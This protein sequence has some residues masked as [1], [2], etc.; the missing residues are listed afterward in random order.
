MKSVPYLHHAHLAVLFTLFSCGQASTDE[1]PVAETNQED[2]QTKVVNVKTE[3]L[4]PQDFA[5]TY[6]VIGHVE[7]KDDVV[8]SSE[9]SG[10]ILRYWV[11]EGYRVKAGQALAKIDDALLLAERDRLIA[12]VNQSKENY[13]R[14]GRLWNE[15][16]IGS[17][18]DFINAKYTFQQ[19]EA[20][21]KNV[22]TQIE[23]T[24]LKAPFA[25]VVDRKLTNM[26]ETVA[27]GTQML[28]LIDDRTIIVAGGVPS[29]YANV[30]KKGSPVKISLESH[31]DT[32]FTGYIQFVAPS[33]DPRSRTFRIEVELENPESII[34]IDAQARIEIE[35]ARFNEVIVV[36]NEYVTRNENG[37]QVFLALPDQ[38]GN[39]I[40]QI[41][42]VNLGARSNNRVVIPEGLEPGEQLIT[43]GSSLVEN[44][45]KINVVES[46][47]TVASTQ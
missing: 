41:R 26:G 39:L 27:P 8:L 13:E 4:A 34:K 43:V 22:L 7:A 29:R 42:K 36:H 15:N 46:T 28:R 9:A 31:P 1:I 20:A 17:E 25:G 30:V 11:E 5:A 3:I 6:E 24:T 33:I 12:S 40:A 44:K 19:A 45:S 16:G 38:D 21:L 37:Y 35:T 23:K 32:A 18:M 14:L 2:A 10:R 47:T